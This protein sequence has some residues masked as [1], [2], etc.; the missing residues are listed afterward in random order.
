MIRT[1]LHYDPHLHVDG[2]GTPLIYVPGMDGTGLLFYRQ[3]LALIPYHRVATYR[4]RDDADSME[5][6]VRDLGTIHDAVS[7]AREP[8]IL[9]GESFGGALAMSFA[10]AHPERVSRL[11]ILNSFPHFTPQL[12]LRLARL[13]ILLMP[14]GAMPL[15]RR[16][17]AH[18]L[19]SRSIE[20]SDRAAFQVLTRKTTKRGYL[21]RLH[22]L[23]RYDLRDRLRDLRPPVLFLAADDDRLIPSV[24]QARLM[25]SL[26]PSAT[27]QVL[28]GFGHCCF[29]AADMD[30]AA[31]LRGWVDD[32][33]PVIREIR[34]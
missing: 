7:P 13:G 16:L 32:R 19:H 33:R 20:R 14:W 28:P 26:A 31:I 3:V 29:L 24:E 1:R 18:R 34:M 27:I 22:N 6:L 17:T 15:V 11:L 12:R 10:L 21:G 8:A 9:V 23:E 5:T 25:A 30:L 2:D 4:L